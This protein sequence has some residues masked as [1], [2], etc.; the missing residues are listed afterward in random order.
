[1]PQSRTRALRCS[2]KKLGAIWASQSEKSAC[3]HSPFCQRHFRCKSGWKRPPGTKSALNEVRCPAKLCLRGHHPATACSYI[4]N[5]VFVCIFLFFLIFD[6]PLHVARHVFVFRPLSPQRKHVVPGLLEKRSAQFLL[7]LDLV[8]RF[9]QMFAEVG[10]SQRNV[11]YI[12]EELDS[13]AGGAIL[14][15]QERLHTCQ[16]NLDDVAISAL[17]PRIFD[18][19]RINVPVRYFGWEACTQEV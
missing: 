11:P 12:V 9:S 7:D 8:A 14:E 15:H 4:S 16:E 19:T 6:L 2:P 10:S 17:L 13:C 5:Q 1:M 3:R 18:P